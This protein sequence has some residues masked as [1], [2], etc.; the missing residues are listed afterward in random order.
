MARQEGN[1]WLVLAWDNGPVTRAEA[2]AQIA[3]LHT[4]W[5]LRH[6]DTVPYLVADAAPHDGTTTDLSL[7]QA[8]RSA[9]PDVDDD[10]NAAIA[11]ILAQIE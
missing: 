11:A 3:Q 1:A 4:D 5:S 2:L 7:W 9:L 8:D 6:G 10:L